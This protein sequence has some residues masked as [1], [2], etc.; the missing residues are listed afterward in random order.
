MSTVYG[1]VCHS[2]RKAMPLL[3]NRS[4]MFICFEPYGDE[5]FELLRQDLQQVGCLT[6]MDRER[7]VVTAFGKNL[8]VLDFD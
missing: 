2:V 1:V 5:T 7:S 3:K 8:A 6:I 4:M